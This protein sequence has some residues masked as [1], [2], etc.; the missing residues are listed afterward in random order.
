MVDCHPV[1]RFI[2]ISHSRSLPKLFSRP[3][4]TRDAFSASQ[5]AGAAA[6]FQ[7]VS[8]SV[9]MAGSMDI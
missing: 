7:W 9:P 2:S 8:G 5:L 1:L 6:L 4:G 3:S